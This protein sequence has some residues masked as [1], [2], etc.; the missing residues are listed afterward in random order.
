[1]GSTSEDEAPPSAR[2]L[3]FSTA[4]CPTPLQTGQ[5]MLLLVQAR[6]KS[7]TSHGELAA[8]KRYVRMP[9]SWLR[10]NERLSGLLPSAVDG[11]PLHVPLADEALGVEAVAQALEMHSVPKREQRQLLEHTQWQPLCA[12]LQ[13]AAWLGST[14]LVAVCEM[15]LCEHVRLDNVVALARAAERCSALKLLTGCFF[16]LKSYFCAESDE[17]RPQRMGRGPSPRLVAQG[18]RQGSLHMPSTAWRS[19]IKSWRARGV[20]LRTAQPCY[21]LCSLVRERREHTP[22]F[23]ELDTRYSSIRQLQVP[24]P[25]SHPK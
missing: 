1:M 24:H 8:R 3:T 14:S 19:V 6:T 18:V 15:K 12:L 21:T 7:L 20:S 4:T 23:V 11:E 17:S 16:L 5:I 10:R 2:F 13:A 22:I 25:S 9:L